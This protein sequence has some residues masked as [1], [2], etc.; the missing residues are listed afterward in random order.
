MM[1]CLAPLELWFLVILIGASNC[2]PTKTDH[3]GGQLH[4]PDG[5]SSSNLLEFTA[6]RKPL[7]LSHEKLPGSSSAHPGVM[8]YMEKLYD[9]GIYDT[10][11]KEEAPSKYFPIQPVNRPMVAVQ[12]LIQHDGGFQCFRQHVALCSV[13]WFKLQLSYYERSPHWLQ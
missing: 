13:D 11:T 4:H 10:E 5:T 9:H 12:Q 3:W 8:S 6:N 7:G 1:A 2:Y